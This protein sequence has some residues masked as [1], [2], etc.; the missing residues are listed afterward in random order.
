MGPRCDAPSP[1]DSWAPYEPT[2]EVP[3]DLGRVVHLHR[4]AG[5]AATWAETRRDLHDGPEATVS[6][7]LAGTSRIGGVP[8]D[9]EATSAL[10]ADA[11]VASGDADRLRAWW[12]YRML[13]SP[14]PLGERLALMWHG[15]FASA[16]S[17]VGDLALMRRQVETFRRLAR[18]PFGELLGEAAREPALLI[19]L[20]AP[21]NRKGHPNENLAR[22]LMELFT[23]GIGQF[24]EGDVREAARALT[25]WRVEDGRFAESPSRHDDG[26][27]TILG[28]KGNLSGSDLLRILLDHPATARRVAWRLCDTLMGEGATD[29]PAIDALAGRLRSDGLDVGRA[30]ATILRSRDF[31]APANLRSRVLG[32]AELVVGACRALVPAGS[33]PSTLIL[34]DWIGRLGQEL[35]EPPNVGGWPGG[36]SWLSARSLVARANLAAALADGKAVGLPGPLDA[37]AIAASQGRGT[38]A[39]D[40]RVAASALLLGVEPDGAATLGEDTP[41]AARHALREVLASPEAQVG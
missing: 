3:W 28:R 10:L 37:Q 29:G 33:M 38:S 39:G 30:V 20:D 24:A 21:A 36:R 41:E 9:F 26:P 19:Y 31:F 32:P 23:L 4:R 12:V 40:A 16:V 2:A 14:D 1:V 11:A 34:A 6:R 15:H 5:F 35:F 27:K 18:A 22:E 25:G 8:E 13:G 17:K 7:V